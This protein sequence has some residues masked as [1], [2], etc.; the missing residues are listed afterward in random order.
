[1]FLG[2]GFMALFGAPV[3]HEDHARRALLAASGVRDRLRDTPDDRLRQLGIRMGLNTGT[4]VVGKIGDNLRMDYTAVGDTTNL[5]ARLQ[6]HAEPGAIRISETTQRAA[7]QYFE[8]TP[9]GKHQL[10]GIAEATLIYDLQGP[11]LADKSGPDGDGVSTSSPLVG[12][13]Q[14]QAALEAS[15]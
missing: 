6:S 10:K 2:D 11:R 12:R 13:E 1:Q 9:L 8:F 5:A 14:E 4:V 3:A 7:L 15:L